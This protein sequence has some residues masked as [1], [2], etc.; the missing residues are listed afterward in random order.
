MSPLAGLVPVFLVLALGV[1]ARRTGV[2][3]E[4]AANGLNR[5]VANVALPAFFLLT[6][7]T[8]PLGD[9]LSGRAVGVSSAL[10]A[11]AAVVS[12]LGA[13]AARMSPDRAGVFAQAAMRGNLAYVALPVVKAS[14]GDDGLRLAAVTAAVL[15]P[16]MNVL[17]VAVLEAER[18][19]GK[20]DCRLA[21][22]VLANPMVASA[23]GGLVL[24]AFGWRPWPW[25]RRTLEIL[26]D[27][28]LPGALL[29]LGAG[30]S[31]G[32]FPSVWR[33]AALATAVKLVAVPGLGLWWMR[34]LGATPMESAVT[35]LLLAA[36][37][38]VVSYPVAAELGGNTDLAGTVILLTTLVSF[39]TYM[40]WA[41]ALGL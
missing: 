29:A 25:L 2:V 4:A 6:V 20:R 34:A 24:A 15:I 11:A 14:A 12:L 1:A 33:P 19:A 9:S 16:L 3:G 28:A 41:V 10:V 30:L 31:V 35:V 36:P 7:G 37:T 8:A 22:R 40:G 5:L 39:A 13:R 23:L 17:S 26:S 27:F 21:A 18:T 38:A 32:R